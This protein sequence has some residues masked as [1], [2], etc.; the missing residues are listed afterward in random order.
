MGLFDD[1]ALKRMV[2]E[3]PIFFDEDSDQKVCRL[4]KE[5]MGS[6]L[7]VR[8]VVSYVKGL[9]FPSGKVHVFFVFAVVDYSKRVEGQVAEL[10]MSPTIKAGM[11]LEHADGKNHIKVNLKGTLPPRHLRPEE[12]RITWA[13]TEARPVD[14]GVRG[15][16]TYQIDG[17]IMTEGA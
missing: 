17:L 5:S 4:L 13:L 3:A 12:M 14:E 1:D 16:R 10:L 2:A 9:G 6:E 11:V 7:S 15:S 8:K